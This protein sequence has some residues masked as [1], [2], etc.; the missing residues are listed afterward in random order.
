MTNLFVHDM[1]YLLAGKHPKGYSW[2]F[3]SLSGW[4]TTAEVQ[5]EKVYLPGRDYPF[6]FLF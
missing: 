5:M 2:P 1:M 3:T 4:L 6:R